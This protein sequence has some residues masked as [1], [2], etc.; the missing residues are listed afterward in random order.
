[1]QKAELI[2]INGFLKYA[3]SLSDKV[4]SILTQYEVQSY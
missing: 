2:S 3:Q 1:M 4:R